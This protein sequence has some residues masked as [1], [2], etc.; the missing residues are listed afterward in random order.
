MLAVSLNAS[1]PCEDPLRGSKG[2]GAAQPG[3]RGCFSV[4]TFA[5]FII[6][7]FIPL[8]KTGPAKKPAIN[9]KI[10]LDKG[11]I[12]AYNKPNQIK[13][14]DEDSNKSPHFREPADGASRHERLK[15]SLLS[16]RSEPAVILYRTSRCLPRLRRNGKGLDGVHKVARIVQFEW[17]R[18]FIKLV[19]K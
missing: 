7:Q 11:N 2:G 15:Q 5:A 10:P 13:G 16:R 17:Y 14:Y 3:R 6:A 18:G 12:T 19:S 9:F 8:C 1:L 4:F